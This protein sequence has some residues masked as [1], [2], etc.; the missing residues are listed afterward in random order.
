MLNMSKN[1]MIPLSLF[2]RVIDLLEYWDIPEHHDLRYEYCN[3]L[4]ELKVKIKK[5]ELRDAYS[6]IISASN[7]DTRHDARIE[8]LRQRSNLGYVDAPE[9]PF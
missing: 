7:E 8:Y 5:L 9:P 6:K 2:M 4:W 1:V 3:I